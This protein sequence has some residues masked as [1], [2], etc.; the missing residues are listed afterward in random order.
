M[1]NNIF[2]GTVIDLAKPSL[3][4]NVV[5]NMKVDWWMYLYEALTVTSVCGY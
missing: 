2:T 1:I 4:G 3:T 5:L